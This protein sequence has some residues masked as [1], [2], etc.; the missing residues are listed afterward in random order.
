VGCGTGRRLRDARAASRV[1]LDLVPEM[2][3][4]GRLSLARAV[5]D[6]RA[7]PLAAASFD[8][9]WC[10]LVLGH[11]REL[12][13]A[14]AELARVCAPDGAVV[15]TDVAEEATAAGHR[16]TFRDAAGDA[17]ELEHHVHPAAAHLEAARRAGLALTARRAGV[18]GSRVEPLYAAA[19]KRAAY[20]E[21]RG[22]PLVLALAFRPAP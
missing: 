10:R 1:G 13:A 22:L 16:R 8:V 9:V 20:M 6:V 3:A 14:Y 11:L 18:V 2:L 5:A 15:V 19:G 12:V 17:H 21:Q 7:L 4:A